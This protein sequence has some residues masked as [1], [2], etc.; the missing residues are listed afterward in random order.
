MISLPTF[1]TT[2]ALIRQRQTTDQD[3]VLLQEADI[4]AVNVDVHLIQEGHPPVPPTSDVPPPH[5]QGRQGVLQVVALSQD[6][7]VGTLEVV[8]EPI[9]CSEVRIPRDAALVEL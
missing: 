2:N 4:D 3:D 7:G 9:K 1:F 5:H 6:V 8:G